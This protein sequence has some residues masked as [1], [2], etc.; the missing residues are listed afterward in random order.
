[1]IFRDKLQAGNRPLEKNKIEEFCFLS[2]LGQQLVN[3]PGLRLVHFRLLDSPICLSIL[4]G[5]RHAALGL[6]GAPYGETS[7]PFWLL[8][9]TFSDQAE[10]LIQRERKPPLR[11][12][13]ETLR[14]ANKSNH[15]N[16]LFFFC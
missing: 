14:S 12:E 11:T 3:I 16:C 5:Q 10:Q 6:S 9:S 1:M 13:K 2:Q 8:E 4:D 15:T 7:S